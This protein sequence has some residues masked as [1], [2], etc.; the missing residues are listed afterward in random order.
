MHFMSLEW[1]AWLVGTVSLYWLLPERSRNGALVA[2]T[3]A[4]LAVYSWES[5]AV[6]TLLTCLTYHLS[7]RTPLS[8]RRV[9]AVTAIVV[10]IL[11]YYKVLVYRSTGEGVADIVIPLGLSYYSFRC[12]HYV[13]ERYRETTP[14]HSFGEYLCYM[15][16]LPTMVIGPINRFQPFVSDI[17]GRRWD[18]RDLSEGIERILYGYVKIAVL[19]NYL[20]SGRLNEHI[21]NIDPGNIA[22]IY[23]LEIVRNGLSLYLQFAGFSDI[24]IGFALLLG[25]RIMENFRWPYLQKNISDFWR[26]WHISLSSWCRDYVYMPVLGVTR[27]PY[28]ATLASF[29]VIGLWHEISY[30]YVLWGLFH[31]AGILVWR[32]MQDA[33]RALRLPRVK[34][35]VGR[36][37]L[38]GLSVV[39]TVHFVFFGLVIVNQPNVE[40][41]WHVWRATLFFWL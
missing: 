15:F 36:I 32:R 21:A 31:G 37:A 33:K 34:N 14:R 35:R 23:Y 38:D 13:F 2:V 18:S 17:H 5:A 8:G 40:K 9:I 30:R 1:L 7:D 27:N 3:L 26:C 12:F 20:V 41:V 24:A 16:F 22:L 10:G 6:L 11:V 19:G 28:M 29:S 25:Y 39:A 4:F